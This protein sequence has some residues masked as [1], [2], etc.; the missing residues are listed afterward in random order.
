MNF[1]RYTSCCGLL[2]NLDLCW[3]VIFANRIPLTIT[4]K[5]LVQFALCSLDTVDCNCICTN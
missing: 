5:Y 2:D 3:N 4:Q 1:C